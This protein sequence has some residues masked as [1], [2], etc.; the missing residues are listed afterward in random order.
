MTN[1][2]GTGL[3]V[4]E[5]SHRAA[6][7]N[8][9]QKKLR[10]DLRILMEIP[11][12]FEILFFQ[13]GASQQFSAMCH[14]LLGEGSVQAANFLTTGLW[15]Q[16]CINEA[17]GLCAANEV[18]NTK[19]HNFVDLDPTSEWKIRKDA[20]F[21]AYCDNETV[22]GFEWNN[23]PREVIP[24]G[25]LVCCDMSSNFAS[26]RVNWPQYDVVYLGA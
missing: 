6:P 21:F 18:S 14:N 11:E 22:H 9:I 8:S 16:L 7:F 17:T 12:E 5:M 2:H 20:T 23:F 4:M 25:Q 24:K 3:S 10:D 15:S 13:G 1:W 19:K 26:R